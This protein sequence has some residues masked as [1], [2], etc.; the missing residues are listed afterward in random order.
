MPI[1]T[2]FVEGHDKSLALRTA[3]KQKTM[4]AAGRP[5]IVSCFCV[6]AFLLFSVSFSVSLSIDFRSFSVKS[7]LVRDDS[8]PQTILNS[9]SQPPT[10]AQIA[11][12]AKPAFHST[13]KT[14]I[15]DDEIEELQIEIGKGDVT[16]ADIRP[17][18]GSGFSLPL[19]AF[20]WSP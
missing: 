14:P 9:A 13:S 2:G 19:L 1:Q 6:S 11:F 7:A 17:A 12:R 8:A 4:D 5:N 3:S 20:S 18:T 15:G 16:T 10:P